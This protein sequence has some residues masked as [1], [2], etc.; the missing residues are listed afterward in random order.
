MGT[1]YT[2]EGVQPVKHIGEFDFD[3]KQGRLAPTPTKEPSYFGR[4]LTP[5]TKQGAPIIDRNDRLSLGFDPSSQLMAALKAGAMRAKDDVIVPAITGPAKTGKDGAATTAHPA[6]Q[7]VGDDVG[8]TDSPLNRDK[9]IAAQELLLA[10]DVDLEA[11]KPCIAIDARSHSAL[12][13]QLDVTDST[14][15]L[16]GVI[17][18]GRV[19]E[20]HGF[21]VV[22]S[23]RLTKTG[24]FRVLPVWVKSGVHL[25]VWEDLITRIDERADLSYALQLYG[26]FV[27]GAT[28]TEEK[29]VVRIHA[30]E[31]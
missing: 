7:L 25:G 14:N 10:A 31:G 22:H 20:V 19:V 26:E 2:G 27:I 1:G 17:V 23:N 13:R 6:S 16:S 21:H 28:R 24:Q 9:L 12:L 4:Y 15:K 30:F 8:G 18:N 3:T 5:I 11:E 29:K